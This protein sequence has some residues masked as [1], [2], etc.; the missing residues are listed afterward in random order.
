MLSTTERLRPSRFPVLSR[1]ALETL[2]VNLGYRCNQ[3]CLHC[4]VAASPSR[5]E[6]MSSETLGL[7]IEALDRLAVTTLDITGGAPELNPGFRR[8][9]ADAHARG[10]RVIDRCNL[11]ILLEPD[12][13]DLAGFLAAQG[14]EVV[15]SLPCYLEENV[16]WQRGARCICARRWS[17]PA[18]AGRNAASPAPSC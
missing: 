12:Q 17:P 9:V 2:Q 5:A 10:L 6:S 11:S 14:V 16:D 13:D 3:S 4:H 7:V 15:A 18:G 1:G 8:L